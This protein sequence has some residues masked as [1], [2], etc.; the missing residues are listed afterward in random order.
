M[1]REDLNT[2]IA[3]LALLISAVTAWFQFSPEP[4]ALLMSRADRSGFSD[5]LVFEQNPAPIYGKAG[6]YISVSPI[7]WDLIIYNP[8]GKK[9]SIVDARVFYGSGDQKTYVSGMLVSFNPYDLEIKDA[10]M[11]FNIESY[12]SQK[13]KLSLKIPIRSPENEVCEKLSYIQ[14]VE[15]CYKADSQ[16]IFGNIFVK[17]DSGKRSGSGVWESDPFNPEFVLEIQTADGSKFDFSVEYYPFRKL[18][19]QE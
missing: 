8:T 16:D 17:L 11:P 15:N 2:G 4:D 14:A 3:T 5:K 19:E 7:S 18:L 10:G 6:S 1:D 12:E 13:F 9:V